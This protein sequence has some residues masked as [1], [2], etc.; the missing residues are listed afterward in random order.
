MK[1]GSL[2]YN[3]DVWDVFYYV[4]RSM[5]PIGPIFRRKCYSIKVPRSKLSFFFSLSLVQKPL[6]FGLSAVP[7]LLNT[8]LNSISRPSNYYPACQVIVDLISVL[9]VSQ[10][11]QCSDQLWQVNSSRH[12]DDPLVIFARSSGYPHFGC[13]CVTSLVQSNISISI[14]G[15]Y[16]SLSFMVDQYSEP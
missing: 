3:K 4:I 11:V 1:W 9:I 5:Y 2:Y 7:F 13:D 10:R 16:R 14:T 6:W 12:K 15:R 8:D